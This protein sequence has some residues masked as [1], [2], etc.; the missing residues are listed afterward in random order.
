MGIPLGKSDRI[1][2]INEALNATQKAR[3]HTGNDHP[4]YQALKDIEKALLD[5][6]D[7]FYDI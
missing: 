3:Y 4:A 2:L 1:K 5:V 7:L 6:G